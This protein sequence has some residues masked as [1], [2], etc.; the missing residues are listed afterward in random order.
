MFLRISRHFQSLLFLKTKE[1]MKGNLASRPLD[2]YFLLNV[3]PWPAWETAEGWAAGIRRGGSPEA[4]EK[5]GKS[6]T[7]SRGT[8]GWARLGLG[9]A[10]ASHVLF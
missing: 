7:A 1:K 8:Q 10:G 2:F 6:S 5:W 9:M 4:W 3:G